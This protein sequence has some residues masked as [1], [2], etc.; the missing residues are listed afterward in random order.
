MK[1][2]TNIETFNNRFEC[3]SELNNLAILSKYELLNSSKCTILDIIMKQKIPINHI[4]KVIS[5][6]RN[7]KK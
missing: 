4:I 6:E 7:A 1:I 2:P 5:E 3:I